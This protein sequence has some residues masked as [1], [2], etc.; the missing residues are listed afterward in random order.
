MLEKM[1]KTHYNLAQDKGK[2]GGINTQTKL[3]EM[4]SRHES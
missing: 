3:A 2:Q 1:T 4:T